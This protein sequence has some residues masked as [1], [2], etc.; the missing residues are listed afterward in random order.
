MTLTQ[1]KK[2]LEKLQPNDAG[3][4][5]WTGY[6][7][8]DGYGSIHSGKKIRAHRAVY[9]AFRGPVASELELLHTCDNPACCNPD[10]LVPGTHAENMRDMANKFRSTKGESNPKAKLTAAQVEEIR[11][12]HNS[13]IPQK[14]LA[15]E[16]SVCNQ[17]ISLI[18]N[19]KIWR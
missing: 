9:E 12:K 14:S 19:N 1:I 5:L 11:R 2:L 13:G 7:R 4:W 16:Y 18:V 17:T 6:R 15:A 3:C 8:A 10:H